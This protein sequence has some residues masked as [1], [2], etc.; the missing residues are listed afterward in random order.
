M[1]AVYQIL[2]TSLLAFVLAGSLLGTVL[3]ASLFARSARA[4]AFIGGMNRWVSTR[5]VLRPVELP[6]ET[7]HGGRGL[8]LVLA[9]AGAYALFVLAQVPVAKIASILRVDAAAT[10][11]LI[12]IEA[13][14]WLLLA[15][16][17]LSVATGVMLVF[18]P[19]AWRAVEARANR[20]YSSRQMAA[21]GDDMHVPLDR[22]A[23]TYPRAAGG[24]ILILSLASA[25]A[26][27]LLLSRL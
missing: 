1:N 21:G 16:C 5:R 8:G 18:F 3:G 6:R 2:L 13:T 14:K 24:L 11:A 23:E 27:A 9:L 4:Q 10:L 20:W 17:A 22:L 7:G 26:T 12:A 15:G 19:Q 25:A